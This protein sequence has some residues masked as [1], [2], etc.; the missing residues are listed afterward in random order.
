MEGFGF[1]YYPCYVP[2]TG[3]K[4]FSLSV[5]YANFEKSFFEKFP[6]RCLYLYTIIYFVIYLTIHTLFFLE[7]FSCIWANNFL[8]AGPREG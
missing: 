6:S 5:L 2:T 7:M 8:P 1:F 4:F 3:T